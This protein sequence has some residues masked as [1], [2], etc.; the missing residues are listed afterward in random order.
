MAFENNWTCRQG[1]GQTADESSQMTEPLQVSEP[2]QMLISFMAFSFGL[3]FFFFENPSASIC[4]LPRHLLEAKLGTCKLLKETKTKP[5]RIRSG[6]LLDR[7]M[8]CP[9]SVISPRPLCDERGNIL[10]NISL[11][12]DS[13]VAMDIHIV[14]YF[15]SKITLH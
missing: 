6:S 2:A 5:T 15:F 13:H 3:F 12:T 10:P 9:A 8:K 14:M 11:G 1:A 4:K 7:M